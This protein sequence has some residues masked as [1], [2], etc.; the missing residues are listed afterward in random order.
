MVTAA[1]AEEEEEEEEEEEVV[2][3]VVAPRT[4]G[5]RR[6]AVWREVVGPLVVAELAGS[7]P[8]V[9]GTRRCC[10]TADSSGSLRCLGIIAG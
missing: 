2:V 7:K 3:V 5:G 1:A 4:T 8:M 10:C 6:T 9:S